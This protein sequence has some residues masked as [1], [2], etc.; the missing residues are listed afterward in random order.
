MKKRFISIIVVLIVF[1]IGIVFFTSRKNLTPTESK[2][3]RKPSEGVGL[4]YNEA[5]RFVKEG[6][7]LNARELYKKLLTEYPES[8]LIKDVRAKLDSLNIRILFSPIPTENSIFYEV[9]PGDNLTK[10]ARN[11]GTT[12]EFI[13]KSNNLESSLI[14]PQMRLKISKAKYSIFVDKSQNILMLKSDDEVLKTYTVSTGENNSTP[15][16]AYNIKNKLIDPTW[17]KAGAIVPPESPENILGSRWMGLDLF[18]YGIHGTTDEAS[19][20]EQITAGCV[21]MKNKEV[22]ELYSIVPVGTAVTIID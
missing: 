14:M 5:D 6:Q 11:F 15:T 2:Q 20:G 18:G 13:M 3:Y 21:R 1:I 10:I 9:K 12:V 17:Y 7:F 19:I 4:L 16:G 8:N 22:E